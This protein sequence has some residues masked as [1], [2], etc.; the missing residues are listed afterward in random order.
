MRIINSLE[1]DKLQMETGAR[2]YLVEVAVT[3][4]ATSGEA[5]AG[6]VGNLISRPGQG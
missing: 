2:G 6:E 4:G 3:G 5:A 1:P